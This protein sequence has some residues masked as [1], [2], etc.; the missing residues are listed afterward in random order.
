MTGRRLVLLVALLG[1]LL[2]AGLWLRGREQSRSTSQEAVLL[3]SRNFVLESTDAVEMGVGQQEEPQ[4]R[5]QK[6]ASGRWRVKTAYDAPAD[7]RRLERFMG[8]LQGLSGEERARG[9][10]WFD[11]FGLGENAFFVR[12]IESGKRTAELLIG[13][14]ASNSFDNFV[15]VPNQEVIYAVDQDLLAKAGFWGAVSS[16]QMT[17]ERWVDLRLFPVRAE[18]LEE[19]EIAEWFNDKQGWVTRAKVAAAMDQESQ[20]LLQSLTALRA[21]SILDPDAQAE[22]FKPL[23][24]WTLKRTDGSTLTLEESKLGD[25]DEP[26]RVRQPAEGI[27]FTVAGTS[28]PSFREQLLSMP[29]E[30]SGSAT[31]VD[32]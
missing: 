19:L 25:A 27:Y 3:V 15:R 17:S 32:S 28:I 9:A 12:L 21:G 30:D 24:R 31:D 16:V 26:L 22:A 23:W 7:A 5:I 11:D 8:A 13:R 1:V 18:A 20:N 4:V 29:Q 10:K 2:G 14:S 6:D